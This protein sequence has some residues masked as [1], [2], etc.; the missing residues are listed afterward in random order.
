MKNYPETNKII[1]NIHIKIPLLTFITFCGLYFF[2]TNSVPNTKM[3]YIIIIIIPITLIIDIKSLFS[4]LINKRSDIINGNNS[5]L[6]QNDIDKQIRNRVYEIIAT[7]VLSVLFCI[8]IF[9]IGN[10]L[11]ILESKDFDYLLSNSIVSV[12]SCD[13]LQISIYL[14]SLTIYHYMEFS[15]VLNYHFEKLS[16]DSFLINQSKEYGFTIVF[17]ITE[18][19]VEFWFDL[20]IKSNIILL[21]G[22]VLLILG[23]SFRIGAEFTAK[24]NFTHLIATVKHPKHQLVTSGIYKISRHPSYFG[25]YYWSIGTQILCLNYISIIGFAF[26]LHKFFSNRIV[27]EEQLLIKFFG[28]DYIDYRERT[29]ILIPF[30][31]NLTNEEKEE[32]LIMNKYNSLPGYNTTSFES[33]EKLD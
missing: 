31:R 17:S 32:A 5:K 24:R 23:Q 4:Y 11:S 7:V 25:F 20:K 9:Y 29:R 15:F 18:F 33:E 26:A 3:T 12:E 22:L 10:C 27:Y 21:I 1:K 28:Q 16:F 13:Y 2:H 8:N 6:S 30:I 14:L 19:L